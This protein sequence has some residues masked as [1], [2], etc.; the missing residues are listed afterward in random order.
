MT[1]ISNEMCVSKPGTESDDASKIT[2]TVK[3][4]E[5]KAEVADSSN[6]N[7]TEPLSAEKHTTEIAAKAGIDS[8]AYGP[9]SGYNTN[10]E[11]TYYNPYVAPTTV[12]S[13]EQGTYDQAAEAYYAQQGWSYPATVATQDY[14]TEA[15]NTAEDAVG[16]VSNE[17]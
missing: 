12:T 3:D 9:Q 5:M 13:A 1:D 14:G 2:S 16:M 7:S 4:E 6:N 17:I 8:E 10:S 11:N 15:T